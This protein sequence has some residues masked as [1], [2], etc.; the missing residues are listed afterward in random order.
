MGHIVNVAG[1]ELSENT[2]GL[3]AD[4]MVQ[5]MRNNVSSRRRSI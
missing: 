4:R 2:V 5:T 3:D 1:R